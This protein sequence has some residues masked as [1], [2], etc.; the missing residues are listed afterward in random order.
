MKNY[1]R[2]TTKRDLMYDFRII[3]EVCRDKCKEYFKARLQLEWFVNNHPD[4]NNHLNRI[5]KLTDK[6]FYDFDKYIE[7]LINEEKY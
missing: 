7:E 5:Y 2:S 6:V 3:S 4:W 1:R